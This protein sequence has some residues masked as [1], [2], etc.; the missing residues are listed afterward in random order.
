[1]ASPAKQ[2]LDR[3]LDEEVGRLFEI[4]SRL[5]AGRGRRHRQEV[6]HRAAVVLTVA[7]WEA[8]VEELVRNVIAVSNPAM[9]TPPWMRRRHEIGHE[10]VFQRVSQLHTPNHQNVRALYE[11]AFGL[12]P[13]AGWRWHAP[14]RRWN[15]SQVKGR[16]KQWLRIRHG[17][18]H[19]DSLPR[20]ILWLRPRPTSA[21]RLTKTHARECVRFFRHVA[22]QTDASVLQHIQA[23]YGVT[24]PW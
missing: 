20:D 22:G 11:A 21:P 6:L 16:L 9:P 24:P 10:L 13:T 2:R 15:A 3:L 23:Q 1:M 19:G 18:A 7:V 14:H 4:H 17:I 12:D 8:Y 5:Q